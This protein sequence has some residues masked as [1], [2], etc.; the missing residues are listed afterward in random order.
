MKFKYVNVDLEA[1][2]RD[3]YHN[4][5]FGGNAYPGMTTV[6]QKPK[7]KNKIYGIHHWKKNTPHAE[8]IARFAADKGNDNVN[9][10]VNYRS[11]QEETHSCH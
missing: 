2:S 5:R 9:H 10:I 3:E 6:M 1:G 7:P 4:S 11:K 8:Y